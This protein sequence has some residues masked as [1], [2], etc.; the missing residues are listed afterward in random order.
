[1]ICDPAASGNGAARAGGGQ[2]VTAIGELLEREAETAAADALLQSTRDGQG[3][4]LLFEGEAG[5][6]KTA[7]LESIA[8]HARDVSVAVLRAAGGELEQSFPFGV[9]GQ[10]LAATVGGL[11]AHERT[12]LLDG[13][14]SLALA[15][16][17]PSA[18]DR[19]PWANS[20]EALSARLHGLYWLCAGLAARQPLVLLVDDAHWA[21]D[22]SLQ[23]LLFMARRMDDMPASL[24]VATRPVAA[25]DWP[26]PLKLLAGQPRATVLHP[27]RLTAGG[28][29]IVVR[30]VIGEE[31]EDV[32]CAACHAATGGN[33]FPQ[34]AGRGDRHRRHRS[35]CCKCLRHPPRRARGNRR[36]GD[37]SPWPSVA[38][39]RGSGP[40]DRGARY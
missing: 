22:P 4:L 38:V 30:R 32:F 7:L 23:W 6:G 8:E 33:P 17:D 35:R 5:V 1:M 40:S 18:R 20:Q 11:G 31:A 21:D 37:G 13:A 14:A 15:A 29:A 24:V 19:P 9:A 27:R 28:S 36:L 2:M 25:G 34:G 16:I 12:T 3:G 26:E 10:L 39:G